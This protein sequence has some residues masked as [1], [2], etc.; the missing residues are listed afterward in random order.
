[1]SANSGVAHGLD[2]GLKLRAMVSEHGVHAAASVVEL[3]MQIFVV[4][5]TTPI[6]DSGLVTWLH[7]PLR[8]CGYLISTNA[9]SNTGYDKRNSSTVIRFLQVRRTGTHFCFLHETL[10]QLFARQKRSNAITSACFV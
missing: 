9:S 1:M 3:F 5:K 8:P 10:Q 7:D 4:S 6:L 2:H